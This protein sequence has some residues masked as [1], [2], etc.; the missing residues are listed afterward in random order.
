M[1]D[2][3]RVAIAGRELSLS[4]LDKVLYPQTGT[5]KGEVIDYYVR[6]AA[7]MLPH[8]R[9]RC[10]TLRRWPD[11]VDG[12]SFFQKRCPAHRPAWIPTSVGPGDRQGTVD[13]CR[14][15]EPAALAWTANLA[16]IELHA[17]MAR[18]EDLDAPTMLVFDLDPGAPAT[19]VECAQVA[20]R[21]RDLLD[22]SSLTCVAKTSGS[23]GMQVLVPLNA[24]HTHDHC[25]D[26]ALAVARLLERQTPEA[27]TSN[28]R[29]SL[30]SGRVL[31]D[32]SQ[33]SRHKT[34]VAPYSLRARSA[35]TVSAP[36]TWGEVAEAA[37]GRSLSFDIAQVLDRVAALGD[38]AG[39]ALTV[40]QQLPGGR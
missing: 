18:C 29:R 13:Y 1:S 12:T 23:K 16:S 20:L 11:G 35:P 22:G 38:L 40:V 19:I 2:P 4:N 21:I 8:L 27:V 28:M 6:I 17:P 9:G 7:V 33:N 36:V 37:G 39:P 24:P 14:V 5:T 31:V 25:R 30:R 26:V 15:E 32:W 10:I 34:T 3:I